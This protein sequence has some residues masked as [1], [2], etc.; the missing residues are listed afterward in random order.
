MKARR[1]DRPFEAVALKRDF[2]SLADPSLH[3]LDS[4]A[5]AQMPSV[6]LEA[7]RRFELE[8]RANVHEGLHRLAR[9]ATERLQRGA[10]PRCDGFCTPARPRRWSSPTA[11][12]RRSTCW[13]I[14]TALNLSLATRSCSRCSSTISNL[15]PWQRLAAERG[16]V[17]RFLP[18]TPDG[19]LDLAWLDSEL[20][21]RCRL[22]ALTHCSNVTGAL[23]DVARVVAAARSIGAKVMLD[24][25]QR[26]P[27]GP[28]TC[29]SSASISMPFPA[30]RPTGRP[31][32]ACCG[33]A[34]SC[35]SR[36][37]HS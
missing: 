11:P 30:T 29:A 13:P 22:V 35:S 27:T 23:T 8:A 32:S 24:G 25:A 31:A 7:L 15:V 10:G 37:R 26:A 9:A 17:L 36:C 6:V 4:A 1:Q 21:P 2:P 14:A 33:A 18:M 3:Y 34:A 16:V 20:T 5:T 28:S 19:R 12:R